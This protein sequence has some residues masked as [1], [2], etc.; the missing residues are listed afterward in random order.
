[1]SRLF[2]SERSRKRFS[3]GFAFVKNP[4]KFFLTPSLLTVYVESLLESG[5]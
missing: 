2:R 4:E 3:R 5:H 1:M